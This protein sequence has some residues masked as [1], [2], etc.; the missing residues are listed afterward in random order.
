MGKFHFHYFTVVNL[1]KSSSSFSSP[2]PCLQEMNSLK[3]LKF[4]TLPYFIVSASGA[5]LIKSYVNL[6]EN[7]NKLEKE[8]DLILIE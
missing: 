8:K 3:P 1:L 6:R 4:F 5:N 2:S 7:T